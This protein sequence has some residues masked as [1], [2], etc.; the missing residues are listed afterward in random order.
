MNKKVLYKWKLYL[1]VE[2]ENLEVD[3]RVENESCLKFL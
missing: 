3:F 2:V 1:C